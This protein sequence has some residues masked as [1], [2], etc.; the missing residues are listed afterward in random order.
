MGQTQTLSREKQSGTE[1]YISAIIER[2]RAAQKQIEYASQEEVD[3]VTARVAWAV[4][5]PDFS[6]KLAD[7]CASETG[8]GNPGDKLLKIRNKVRGVF[9]DM[10]GCR[11]TG[12]VFNDKEKRIMK[13]AKPMGVVGAVLPV[14]N[15]EATP[16][17]KALFAL[18]TRNA[19]VMAA[20]PRAVRTSAMVVDQVRAVLKRCGWPED[21]VI[22]IDK[23]SVEATQDLMRQCDIVLATGGSAMVSAAYSSG[24]PSQGVG[25]GNAVCIIDETADL[26]E[27]AGLISKSK[28]FDNAVSC[29]TENSL[30]I[31]ES[32]YDEMMTELQAA[33]GYLVTPGE[34]PGLQAAMFTEK[35]LNPKIVGQSVEK[36]A[37]MAEINLPQNK[38]F[39]LIEET[40]VGRECPFSGEKLSMTAAVYKYKEFEEAVNLVKSIT[41]YSGKGHSCGIHTKNDARV[42]ELGI[43]A[44]VVRLMVRQ[45]QVLANGG[46]WGNGMPMT[47]TLGCGSWG[48]NSTSGNV[49]WEHLLNYT[50]ISYPLASTQPPD[51]ELFG[52]VMHEED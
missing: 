50:W 45:P 37:G 33:G 16:C 21:L 38:S 26:K 15:S 3:L 29:S 20:H 36:I 8:M 5:K 44:P 6:K 11:S 27:A 30:V 17:C 34:K 23:V 18:K 19:V 13:V 10:K 28:T 47:L 39:L 35:G 42:R 31:H 2:A 41:E 22:N 51:E 14:T 25:A 1:Q 48:G 4:V 49:T 43:K 52:S 9:R 12:I 32:V 7:F 24:T 46:F 40:G